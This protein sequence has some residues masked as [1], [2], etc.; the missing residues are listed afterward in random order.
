MYAVAQTF[1]EPAKKAQLGEMH[2]G[3]LVGGTTGTEGTKFALEFFQSTKDKLKAIQV[4]LTTGKAKVVR[5]I[6]FVIERASKKMD[7][8][9]IGAQDCDWQPWYNLKK[10]QILI[11]ISGAGGWF[12]DAIQFHFNN[13]ST[14]PVYGGNGGDNDF[15]LTVHKKKNNLFTSELRGLWGTIANNIETLGLVHMPME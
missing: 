4:G 2:Y 6:T 7:T 5:A 3:P 14:T 12:I 1:K 11:G 8:L 10:N 13:G 15:K 9:T